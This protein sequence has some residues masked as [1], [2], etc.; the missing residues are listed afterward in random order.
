MRRARR[1]LFFVG[2]FLFL[3]ACQRVASTPRLQ[4]ETLACPVQ[5][6]LAR[7][8]N[9]NAQQIIEHLAYTVSYNPTWKIP[10]WVAYS[11]TREE[12]YG[13]VPREKRFSPDPM[14][15]GERVTH[16][17]YTNSGYDRGHMAPAGDMKWSEQAMRESFYMSNICPQN[18]NLNG[19]DWKALEELARDW[20]RKYDE[21]FIVC[22]PIV[23][24]DYSTIGNEH[25]IAVPS[26][27]YKVFLRK[28]A[29]SWASIGFVFQNEPGHKPLL[30]YVASV[31]EIEELTGI[32]FFYNLPDDI[33]EQ[34]ESDYDI[35]YWIVDRNTALQKQ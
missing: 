34:V 33:E 11:L 5:Y 21:V 17:D 24:P 25:S 7:I 29:S 15:K 4:N 6:E 27:F 2:L 8:E 13:D 32:D 26:A 9:G 19:G 22:G 23:Y 3:I 31:N 28:T 18:H 30:T 20:A 12:T 35:S 1:Y 10:N 16:Q 14:V